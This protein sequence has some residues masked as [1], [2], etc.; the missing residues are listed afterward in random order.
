[1]KIEISKNNRPANNKD[2]FEL[3]DIEVQVLINSS[4]IIIKGTS[5]PII[6]KHFVKGDE[7]TSSKLLLVV[8]S[9][10]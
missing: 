4:S 5:Y 2:S 9:I 6:K 1:M 10:K 8:A 7:N 3:T